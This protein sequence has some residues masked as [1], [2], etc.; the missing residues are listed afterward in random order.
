MSPI[1][2]FEFIINQF[3]NQQTLAVVKLRKHRSSFDDDRLRDE[4]AEQQKNG[5]D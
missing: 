5:D 4:N 2:T 3:I 1:K